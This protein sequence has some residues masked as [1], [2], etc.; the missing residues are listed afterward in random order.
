MDI[1]ELYEKCITLS[2]EKNELLKEKMDLAE[3]RHEKESHEKEGQIQAMIL[4]VT[5]LNK[6]NEQVV[7]QSKSA[8]DQRNFVILKIGHE[9]EECL[10]F[11]ANKDKI[12]KIQKSILLKSLLKATKKKPINYDDLFYE[13]AKSLDE[14]LY[15]DNEEDS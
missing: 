9:L 5:Q 7:K 1:N 8:I 13:L 4:K 14:H 15:N 2:K 3:I 11:K 12:Q 6:K 10:G